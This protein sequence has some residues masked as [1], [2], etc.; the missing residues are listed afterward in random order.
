MK[1]FT[2]GKMNGEDPLETEI[3]DDLQVEIE[4]LRSEMIEKIA[5]P[6]DDLT[7]K[8]LE[9]EEIT[10]EEL[11]AALRKGIFGEQGHSGLLPGPL[12]A[13]KASSQ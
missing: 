2:C 10:P 1:K 13:T 11:K 7:L 6:D 5:E 4:Q 8:Y 3:P 9:G 12:C